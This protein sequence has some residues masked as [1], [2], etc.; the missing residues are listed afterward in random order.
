MYNP[1]LL[2]SCVK[3]TDLSAIRKEE[4]LEQTV[5]AYILKGL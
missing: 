4:W 3:N 5:G 1:N 2:D